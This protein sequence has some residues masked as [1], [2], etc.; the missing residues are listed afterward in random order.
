MKTVNDGEVKEKY[1]I[2]SPVTSSYA[3]PSIYPPQHPV[4]NHHQLFF[5]LP[6]GERLSSS[7]SNN[8]MLIRQQMEGQ[9]ILT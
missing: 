9:E 8:R 3:F 5:F 2:S 7:R 6:L 4:H 1:W